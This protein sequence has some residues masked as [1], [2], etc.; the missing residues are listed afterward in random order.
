MVIYPYDTILCVQIT[1]PPTVRCKPI[2]CYVCTVPYVHI[3]LRYCH[4]GVSHGFD[5]FIKHKALVITDFPLVFPT[6]KEAFG[7]CSFHCGISFHRFEWT[8][9]GHYL[10]FMTCLDFSSILI[11]WI[12][13][14]IYSCLTCSNDYLIS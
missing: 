5:L 6:W 9:L 11:Y 1:P 3:H 2:A 7:F 10:I 4:T 13:D 8:A 12:S 14:K